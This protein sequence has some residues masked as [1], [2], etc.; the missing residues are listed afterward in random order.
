[1]GRRPHRFARRQNFRRA[2]GNVLEF[3]G[4]DV[5]GVDKTREGQFVLVGR[6][7][8]VA[9]DFD[10]RIIG[11]VGINMAGQAEPRR[12]QRQ[13]PAQL[14]AADDA[15]ARARGDF[16]RQFAGLSHFPAAL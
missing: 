6:D 8:G 10:R 15:H 11:A 1:M 16:W 4:H 13:H 5:D 9:R 7:G 12:R 14:A 2:R 3:I